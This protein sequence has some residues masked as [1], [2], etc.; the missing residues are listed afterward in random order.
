MKKFETGK[1][2][3][4]NGGGFITV[5]K[6]TECYLWYD[7]RDAEKGMIE[8][9]R[10]TKIIK[11]D[12]FGLGENIVIPTKYAGFKLFCFAGNIEDE[13]EIPETVEETEIVSATAIY[14][15]G[16]IYNYYGKMADGHFFMASDCWEGDILVL[17][18]DPLESIEESCYEEWQNAHYV[19]EKI[20][21]F[22]FWNR[23]I[24]FIIE[25]QPEGNYDPFELENR[26]I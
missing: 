25:H 13:P 1:T 4:V 6:R 3:M 11:D 21:Y 2:Y 17:D 14:T 12:L 10:K 18:A 8:E 24:D 26:K 7:V 5:T 19:D 9:S 23:M 16:G 20:D 22:A 15:G